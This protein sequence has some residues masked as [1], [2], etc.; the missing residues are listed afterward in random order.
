MARSRAT[1]SKRSYTAE[2]KA[3]AYLVL[4]VNE[5]NMLKTS[6][7]IGIPR[8]TLQVWNKE[9][10]TNGVPEEIQELA[11]Q[12]VK[13]FV[14]HAESVRDKALQKL[15]QLIPH[16]TA[17]D[18]RA[19]LLTVA[20]LDDKIRLARGLATKRSEN[21]F[22]LP[23]SDEIQDKIAA[24]VKGAAQAVQELN[25]QNVIDGEATLVEIEAGTS[26]EE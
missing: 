23:N 6:R 8:P 11:S 10:E 16:A 21:V 3:Q 4:Q 1:H 18:I 12:D 19:V 13:E 24:M 7:E 20:T 9:W 22:Q 25:Q 17:K 14:S 5:G 2:E 15:E 26:Q